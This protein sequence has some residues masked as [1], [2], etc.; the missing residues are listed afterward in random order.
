MNFD[1]TQKSA[2]DNIGSPLS[3]KYKLK[4]LIYFSVNFSD[5][6]GKD[7]KFVNGI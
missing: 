1:I 5:S 3:I 4:D 2:E 7:H 6:L